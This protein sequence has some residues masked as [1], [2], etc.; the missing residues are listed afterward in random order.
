MRVLIINDKLTDE[1][2]SEQ[3]ILDTAAELRRRNYDVTLSTLPLSKKEVRFDVVYIHNIFDP[4]AYLRLSKIAPVVHYVHD[5]RSYSPSLSRFHFNSLDICSS[6]SLTH[7]L[8]FSYL[9][10]CSTRS[11]PKL[12]RTYY[13]KKKLIKAQNKI[14]KVIANSEFTRDSLIHFGVSKS[15]I[16]LIHPSIRTQE[17]KAGDKTKDK[18][19]LFT[20]R[21]F[22]EKG[23]EYV[24][25]AMEKVDNGILWI[26]GTGWDEERL[27]ELVKELK[28]E[29][30]VKFF[31]FVDSDKLD[32]FYQKA[33]LGVVPSIWPEPFGLSGLR[34]MSHSKSVV[35]FDS[36]GIKDWLKDS[37]T[38]YLVKRLDVE[39]LADKINKLLSDEKLALE[40]G[41]NGYHDFQRKFSI[42]THVD[43]LEKV[44]REV[45]G[46]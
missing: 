31:G 19:I 45:V 44:F 14:S 2:G 17:S 8:V 43:R 12:L 22:I 18:I 6:K 39:Q 26:L 29:H 20:G 34:F 40:M 38:G 27:K 37:E 21:L 9:E 16:E 36:G 7:F 10:R 41:K 3:N 25:R 33:Y 5:H 11:V 23:V 4:D 13:T 42:K 28:I 1:G 32:D 46:K 15:N 24:I 30:K 35:A